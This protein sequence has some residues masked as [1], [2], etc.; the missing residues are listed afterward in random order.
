ME[1]LLEQRP[2]ENDSVGPEVTFVP[3]WPESFNAYRFS[4]LGF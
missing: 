2:V 4:V 3:F 1:A